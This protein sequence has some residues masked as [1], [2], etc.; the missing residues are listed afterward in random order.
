[1]RFYKISTPDTGRI[2]KKSAVLLDSALHGLTT[3]SRQLRAVGGSARLLCRLFLCL[4]VGVHSSL[5]LLLLL[6]LPFLTISSG[7]GAA[8]CLSAGGDR[9]VDQWRTLS[10][11]RVRPPPVSEV[12][13]HGGYFPQQTPVQEVLSKIW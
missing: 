3:T 4:T 2:V 7:T 8:A 5:L 9:A 10:P 1:M 12:Q 11:G 13:Q 6:L